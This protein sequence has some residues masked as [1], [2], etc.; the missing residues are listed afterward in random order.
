MNR[1]V[2]KVLCHVHPETATVSKSIKVTTK[3]RHSKLVYV[4]FI[5]L[6]ESMLYFITMSHEYF[7]WGGG[8]GG[9]GNSLISFP[10][11][12]VTFYF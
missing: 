3:G 1:H 12:A 8:G 7:P 5:V 4:D 11:T 6:H 9:G 10:L 2:A